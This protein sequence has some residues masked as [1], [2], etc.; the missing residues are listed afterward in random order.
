MH[1]GMYPDIMSVIDSPLINAFNYYSPMGND[2]RVITTIQYRHALRTKHS[3][4]IYWSYQLT[5]QLN[6]QILF[7]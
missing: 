6:F 1:V 2:W 3:D 7:L 5:E 4:E